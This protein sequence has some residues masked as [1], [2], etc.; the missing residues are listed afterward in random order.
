MKKLIVRLKGGMGNQMF[1]YAAG[2]SL[3]LKYGMR[4]M[5][6]ATSGFTHD[7]VYRRTYSLN[8]FPFTVDPANRGHQL[9][10]W[11]EVI[12]NK[13]LGGPNDLVQKR[14]WGLYINE[15]N[16]KYLS[17]L[18][19][20]NFEKNVFMEGF[21]QSEYYFEDYKELLNRELSPPLPQDDLFLSMAN[22]IEGCNAVSVG[23]RLFEEVPGASKSGVGGLVPYSFYEA[24]AIQ[25]AK[26][27]KDPTFFVF[28]TK[29]D[30][31]RG[32]LHL[33]GNIHYLTHDNG[34]KS[35]MN[36][37]WLISRCAHH[38]LSNSSFYWWGAWL[39]EHNHSNNIIIACDKFANSDCIPARWLSIPVHK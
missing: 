35:K 11:F 36:R 10:F 3:A 5:L 12:R 24:A 6:D 18:S 37:L 4:L 15:T 33:P 13:F 20:I 30:G 29:D 38:I 1:Q 25:I 19:E 16:S 28:C 27:I 8:S 22:K 17:A 32:K 21:W 34:Y 7:M 2:R 39:S 23:V 31:I 14:P 26:K 9:P